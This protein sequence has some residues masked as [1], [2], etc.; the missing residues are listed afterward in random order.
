MK[1]KSSNHNFN[2]I[3]AGLEF[4]EFSKIFAYKFLALN[5]NELTTSRGD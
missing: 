4:F 2:N 5:M 3:K 1:K